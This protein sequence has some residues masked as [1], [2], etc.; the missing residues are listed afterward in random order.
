MRSRQVY[1]PTSDGVDVDAVKTHGTALDQSSVTVCP[2]PEKLIVEPGITVT[3]LIPAV[4]VKGQ[5][6]SEL[7]NL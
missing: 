7:F 2:S 6:L 5:Q 1:S 4:P 3:V